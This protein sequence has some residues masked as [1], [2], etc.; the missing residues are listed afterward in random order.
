MNP[1]HN[2][3]RKKEERGREGNRRGEYDPSTL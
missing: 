1:Q 2:N 3:N